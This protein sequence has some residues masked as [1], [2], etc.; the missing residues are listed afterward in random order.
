VVATA[1]A[2]ARADKGHAEPLFWGG[3]LL[4]VG[5]LAWRAAGAAVHRTE[6]ILLV[7]ACVVGLYGV[8][9]FLA[10]TG[11]AFTGDEFI[12][13]RTA[14]DIVST[15]HLFHT[16]PLNVIS[17]RFPGLEI[18]LVAIASIAHVPIFTAGLIVIGIARLL[19]A[20]SLFLTVETVSKSSRVAAIS[21]FVYIANPN[22]LF[23]GS[24]VSYE[25]LALPLGSLAILAVVR[26]LDRTRS[27]KA[28]FLLSGLLIAAL[29]PTHHVASYALA[30][31]LLVWAAAAV[32]S[33]RKDIALPVAILGIG[34]SAAAASW[35]AFVAPATWSYLTQAP[36][37][38]V[39]QLVHILTGASAPRHLFTSGGQTVAPEW[40]HLMAFAAVGVLL[41]GLP[42]GLVAV[43][44]RHRADP[45]AWVLGIAAALYPA[46]LALRL[47]TAGAEASNR[48]SEY[49]FAGL[50]LALGVAAA[51]ALTRWRSSVL[52]VVLMSALL[53]AF[54]G[55]VVTG[56]AR[57][58]RL[59]GPYLAAAGSRSIGPQG[60]DAARWLLAAAGPNNRL[61][62]DR[63][64]T[65]LMAVLGRQDS[66]TA[67]GG[68]G[69]YWPLF[70][71]RTLT[72]RDLSLIRSN[73]VKYVVIDRRL[74]HSLPLDEV[75]V[76]GG[77]PNRAIRP[78]DL[79][80]FDGVPGVSR[81][82]DSGAMQ[83]YN[84]SGLARV[85]G[86]TR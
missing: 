4:I 68:Q 66:L 34:A 47:T 59:P 23:E 41:V 81:I 84:V 76:E 65:L 61:A 58:A 44:R 60:E 56:W 19:I 31:S 67:G 71:D 27:R 83:I 10:P 42:F 2:S 32:A 78:I 22:F 35:A 12:H 37:E 8:K 54:V 82:Y 43:W 57:H 39:A 3:L 29:V 45:L 15:G 48:A 9:V 80:K 5:P 46:S 28:G 13:L 33:R 40:E 69:S 20:M 64:S 21:V 25:S 17:P 1:D 77:E 6:R 30:L 85:H 24:Q 53:V 16:N 51:A 38:G 26:A 79:A 18:V 63:T 73:H 52:R 72:P 86:G 62:A 50:G 7:A 70:F 74:G 49:V 14:Q 55:G 11:F 75:Y 36:S